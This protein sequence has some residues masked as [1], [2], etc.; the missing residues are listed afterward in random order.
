M[1][2]AIYLATVNERTFMN[3]FKIYRNGKYMGDT[4]T[5]SLKECKYVIRRG[6]IITHTHMGEW[7]RMPTGYAYL[8]TTGVTVDFVRF[9]RDQ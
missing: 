8:T 2:P 7:R 4:Q 9:G 6:L 1:T 3:Y 5:A